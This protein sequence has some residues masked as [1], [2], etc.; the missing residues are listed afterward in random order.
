MSERLDAHILTMHI[1]WKKNI[2]RMKSLLIFI[3][4]RYMF[5]VKNMFMFA[6]I[7]LPYVCKNTEVN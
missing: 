1:S 3:C 5:M 2:N 4:L 7:N 6:K